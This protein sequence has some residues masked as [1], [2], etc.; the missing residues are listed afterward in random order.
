MDK[1]SDTFTAKMEDVIN[2]TFEGLAVYVRDVNLP[3]AV[4]GKYTPGLLVREPAFIEASCRV[5]GM[6]TTHRFGILSNHMIS[7]EEFERGTNWGLYVAN[8]DSRFKVMAVREYSGKTL[9]LLLH[10]PDDD[11]WKAFRNVTSDIEKD[12][13][14][15]AIEYL[16]EK[17]NLEVIPELATGEW[18]Q[19]CAFPIGMDDA[20]NFYDIETNQVLM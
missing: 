19:R 2:R 12:I 1:Q 3:D 9:I 6:C 7:L 8:R 17:C 10:L 20:G 4:A 13:I 5:M 15:E 11:D 14:S 18:Q 16:E